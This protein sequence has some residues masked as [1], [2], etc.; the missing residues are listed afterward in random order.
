MVGVL[1]EI[2][3]I[4]EWGMEWNGIRGLGLL[5]SLLAG[6]IPSKPPTRFG[7]LWIRAHL[8][9]RIMPSVTRITIF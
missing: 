2:K 5:A 9:T 8:M 1:D 7:P 6:R 3:A 4:R